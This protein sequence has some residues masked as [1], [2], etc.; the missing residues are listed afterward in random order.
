[1]N[2]LKF[3]Q[4]YFNL[5]ALYFRLKAQVATCERGEPEADD[6]QIMLENSCFL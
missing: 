1:M 5:Y 6:F 2:F 4:V 3:L